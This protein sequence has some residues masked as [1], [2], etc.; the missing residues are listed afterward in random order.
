MVQGLKS[1]CPH[2]GWLVF[3]LFAFDADLF[4][5]KSKVNEP[6]LAAV[7]DSVNLNSH[8]GVASDS[9]SDSSS[10]SSSSSDSD[11]SDEDVNMERK[12]KREENGGSM[13]AVHKK[14]RFNYWKF[15]HHFH[16]FSLSRRTSFH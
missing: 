16:I 15:L 6:D 10:S 11:S 13:T 2:W 7:A 5:F 4:P 9:S 14:K 8:T 3:R 12:G 1:K